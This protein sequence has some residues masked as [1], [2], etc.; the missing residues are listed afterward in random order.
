MPASLL[1]CLE[2]RRVRNGVDCRPFLY[3]KVT[4]VIT[5][6]PPTTQFF[7]PGWQVGVVLFSRMESHRTE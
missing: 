4:D 5:V 2:I 1:I 6:K 3:F 7:R